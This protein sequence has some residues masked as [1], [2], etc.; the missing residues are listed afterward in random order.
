MAA[1]AL[2]AAGAASGVLWDAMISW[3]SG[4]WVKMYSSHGAYSET[5]SLPV[6]ASLTYHSLMNWP[7]YPISEVTDGIPNSPRVQSS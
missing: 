5:I 7:T 2:A 1:E 4:R 6:P 3:Y